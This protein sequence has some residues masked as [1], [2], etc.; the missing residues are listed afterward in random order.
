MYV[1]FG[2]DVFVLADTEHSGPFP[3]RPSATER[4][5]S[6][7]A[8][9]CRCQGPRSRHRRLPRDG[10]D[11]RSSLSATGLAQFAQVFYG[12]CG[13]LQRQRSTSKEALILDPWRND[14]GDVNFGSDRIDERTV[15]RL[16]HALE[17]HRLLQHDHHQSVARGSHSGRRHLRYENLLV[18]AEV[19]RLQRE[20]LR[21]MTSSEGGRSEVES[22]L[23][24]EVE[25]KLERHERASE[26][27]GWL[28]GVLRRRA[29]ERA[30]KRFEAIIN[31]VM[32]EVGGELPAKMILDQSV[33]KKP[34]GRASA[35]AGF[36]ESDR[37]PELEPAVQPS[38]CTALTR[39]GTRCRNQ[40]EE[41]GL[42]ALHA[43]IAA[44]PMPSPAP[45]PTRDEAPLSRDRDSEGIHAATAWAVAGLVLVA[46][47]A[48]TSFPLG[49][50]A[51]VGS[52]VVVGK[53][54]APAATAFESTTLALLHAASTEDGRPGDG[55]AEARG[56]DT[57]RPSENPE[58]A[59]GETVIPTEV[60]VDAGVNV[61]TGG[62]VVAPTAPAPSAPDPGPTPDGG[63][64]DGG[65]P[66]S[67]SLGGG[68]R[69]ASRVRGELVDE[70][71]GRP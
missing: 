44:G 8:R 59:A 23:L 5:R 56:P 62:P 15:M 46:V 49:Q 10:F 29:E 70:M 41:G 21:H 51:P 53:V 9:G 31:A 60:V 50:D 7:I 30:R 16:F 47:L 55:D 22:V 58:D 27:L 39:R 64:D 18:A 57:G 48:W 12:E 42:C 34:S 13:F 1:T 66:E 61:D 3:P 11:P 67:P 69:Q 14:S 19:D 35:Q 2:G 33:P 43:R 71:L 54:A 52:R 68:G 32:A 38:R 45:E 24:A 4:R 20:C 63:A 37:E 6:C 17:R 40:A 65:A 25:K 28:P 36:P 26:R